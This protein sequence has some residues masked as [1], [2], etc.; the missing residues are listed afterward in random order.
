VA[1][2]DASITLAT[3]QLERALENKVAS[4]LAVAQANSALVG[5]MRA[6]PG[7]AVQ[8]RP[9]L[10]T[11][12]L[13]PPPIPSKPEGS[14]DLWFVEVTGQISSL[15][16]RL[17]QVL[18]TEGEHI[19]NLV[20]NLILTRVHRFT[21]NFPFTQILETFGDDAVGRAAEETAQATM[22]GVVAQLQQR[23]TRRAPGA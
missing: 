20:G 22:V 10:V 11:L 1:E 5:T 21:P 3:T 13:K 9:A 17:G 16:E 7:L 14:I 2:R 4:S 6:F 18:R 8:V 12:G 19:V 15:P 23:V